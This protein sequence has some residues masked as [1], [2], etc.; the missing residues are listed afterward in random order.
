MLKNGQEEFVLDLGENLYH[1]ISSEA[2]GHTNLTESTNG[3]SEI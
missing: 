3:I 2:L 1:Y